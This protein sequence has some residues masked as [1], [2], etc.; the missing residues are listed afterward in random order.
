MKFSC[1]CC[2]LC[3]RNVGKSFLQVELDRGDGVCKNLSENNLC[4]IYSERPLFCNVDAYW[5]KYLSEVMSRE[6]FHKINYKV[7]AELKKAVE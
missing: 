3:C 2:G 4:K 1:D 5:E 7:C 6:Q